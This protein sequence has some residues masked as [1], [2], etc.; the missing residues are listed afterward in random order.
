MDESYAR[1]RR[2]VFRIL[3]LRNYNDFFDL[4]RDAELWMIVRALKPSSLDIYR[5]WMDWVE[6]AERKQTDQNEAADCDPR[7]QGEV[8]AN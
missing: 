5:V 2:H 1:L 8:R 6:R 7:P 4:A 3:T